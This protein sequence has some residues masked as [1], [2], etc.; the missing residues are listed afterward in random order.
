MYTCTVLHI[1]LYHISSSPKRVDPDFTLIVEVY[2]S[3]P[4]EPHPPPS[5]SSSSGKE[6]TPMKV[7]RKLKKVLNIN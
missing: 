4:S 6:S 7:L 5:S 1:Y 3:V 2:S